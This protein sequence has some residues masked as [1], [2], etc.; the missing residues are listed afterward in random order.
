MIDTISKKIKKILTNGLIRFYY[1]LSIL[2]I[3]KKKNIYQWID[4]ISGQ[5]DQ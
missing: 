4:T 3:E 1:Q 2:S 5:H